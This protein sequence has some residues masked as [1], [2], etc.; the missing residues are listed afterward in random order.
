M[1]QRGK[2]QEE[3]LSCAHK[4]RDGSLPLVGV[5]TFSPMEHGGEV[6]TEFEWIRS[7]PEGGNSS[8]RQRQ[9]LAGCAKFAG[10]GR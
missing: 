8:D 2:I 1:V 3:R 10:A 7:M 9:G 4:K 5:N 6:A